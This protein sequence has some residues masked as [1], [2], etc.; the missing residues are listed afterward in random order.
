MNDH[1]LTEIIQKNKNFIINDLNDKN[2]GEFR[3]VV[4][5]PNT[6]YILDVLSLSEVVDRER[7]KP[8]LLLHLADSVEHSGEEEYRILLIK[9]QRV[10]AELKKKKHQ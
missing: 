3:Y 1:T 2:L 10:D 5:Y 6:I 9:A 7:G 4:L 8:L